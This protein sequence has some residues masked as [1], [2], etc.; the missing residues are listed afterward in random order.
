[1]KFELE[2]L[3]DITETRAKFDKNNPDW[4]RQQNFITIISTLGL[5]VNP[6]VEKSP[7]IEEVASLSGKGFGSRYKGNNCIWKL[8]FIIDQEDA[9]S[10][11]MMI[12]DFNLV[13]VITN[14]SET[15]N[16]KSS[17][18]DTM[19]KTDKNIIFKHID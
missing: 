2:T 3:I 10:V 9:H 7:V 13:P 16:L 19:S 8:E 15:V 4:H 12:N 5:R 14:L 6:V 18:F 1:M 17:V 11:E